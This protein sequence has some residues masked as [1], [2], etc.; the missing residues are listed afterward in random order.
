MAFVSSLLNLLLIAA[1]WLLVG[2]V[3]AGVLKAVLP[4]AWVARQLGGSGVLPVVKAALLGAPMPLCSCSVVPVA[5]GLRRQGAGK[6]PTVSFLVSTPETGVDSIA[7]S[8]ALLGPLL[9]IIRPVAAVF[10]ALIAG[11]LAGGDDATPQP[12]ITTSSCGGGC[13]GHKTPAQ[14]TLGRRLTDGI[15]YTLTTLYRDLLLWLAIGLLAAAAV[16][17]YAPP[18]LLASWG[19]GWTG[20]LVML[21]VG[22]PMYICATA[23]TPLAASLLLAGVSPGAV[24]VFLLAGPATNLGTLALV[25]RELGRRAQVG[26]VAGV[27]G[28]ALL[29]GALTDLLIGQLDA[30]WQ[31]PAHQHDELLPL[32]LSLPCLLVLLLLALPP[33]S[34]WLGRS[35]QGATA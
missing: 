32:W 16:A 5:F 14:T 28:G 33:V 20:M 11:L 24:L 10:S 22:I 26:Y 1:P 12:P 8:Y 6:G 30:S 31:L 2:L 27:A 4:Q 18:D 13:C 9:A 15:R 19:Q 23:S 21:V 25:G 3:L 17:A 34:R 7:L 35:A 29:F